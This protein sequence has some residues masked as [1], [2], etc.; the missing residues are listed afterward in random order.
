[1]K[2]VRELRQSQ[3]CLFFVPSLE[4]S[5][6]LTTDRV[7]DLCR[8]YY[9]MP[10]PSPCIDPETGKPYE[11][12]DEERTDWNIYMLKKQGNYAKANKLQSDRDAVAGGNIAADAKKGEAEVKGDLP[13]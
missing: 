7:H 2:E 4:E 12:T 1:M 5:G 9:Q 10:D 13:F 3:Q 6:K 8:E 11:L